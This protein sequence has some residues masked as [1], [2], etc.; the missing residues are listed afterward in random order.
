MLRFK[1][2]CVD[3][4]KDG[5]YNQYRAE[6]VGFRADDGIEVEVFNMFSSQVEPATL[7]LRDWYHQFSVV[8]ECVDVTKVFFAL[9]KLD[10]LLIYG[11]SSKWQASVSGGTSSNTYPPK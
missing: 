2:N 3:M 1:V 6:R 9:E 10:Y 7:Y 4:L 11:P 5:I 8:P